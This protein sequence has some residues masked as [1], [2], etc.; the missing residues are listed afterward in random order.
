MSGGET[1]LLR[2]TRVRLTAL[3]ESDARTIARWHEDAEY[4]RL[5]D[6]NA[7]I[8]RTVA[9]ISSEIAAESKAA[10]TMR[11]LLSPGN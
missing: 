11:P 9:D 6:T 4:L 7:A 8:P 3:E 1:H 10:D 5:Q 2:S